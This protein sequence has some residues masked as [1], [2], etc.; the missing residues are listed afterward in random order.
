[1][2]ELFQRH[3][4]AIPATAFADRN[5]SFF[6][7]SIP[8]H[9][10]VRN[11]GHFRMPDPIPHLLVPVIDLDPDPGGIQAVRHLLRV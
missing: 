6:H 4:P 3:R 9:P 11:L 1:M 8:H 5:Q 2:D 7:F 10:D